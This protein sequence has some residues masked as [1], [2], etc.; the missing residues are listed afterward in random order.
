M[1]TYR[2][3]APWGE[4]NLMRPYKANVIFRAFMKVIRQHLFSFPFLIS[5]NQT[6][7]AI[8]G[9]L[10]FDHADIKEEKIKAT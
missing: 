10:K 6:I 3:Y 7:M 1:S 4:K 2:L 5:K 9:S 8:L